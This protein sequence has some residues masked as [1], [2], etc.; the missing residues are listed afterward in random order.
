[1]WGDYAELLLA[2]DEPG[3]KPLCVSTGVPTG[4]PMGGAASTSFAHKL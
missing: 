4:V 3:D 1:M 2:L